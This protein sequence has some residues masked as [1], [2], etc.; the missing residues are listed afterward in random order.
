MHALNPARYS[1]QTLMRVALVTAAVILFGSV[2]LAHG[3]FIDTCKAVASSCVAI[4]AVTASPGHQ[5]TG[6][7]SFRRS[8]RRDDVSL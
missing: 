4:G 1:R 6:R 3:D 2:A 7:Q 5:Q 8:G